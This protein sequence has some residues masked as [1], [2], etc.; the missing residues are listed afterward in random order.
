MK[1]QKQVKAA[2]PEFVT[3]KNLEDP[4]EGKGF[5]IWQPEDTPEN[6]YEHLEVVD[7]HF[8]LHFESLKKTLKLCKLAFNVNTHFQI[9]HIVCVVIL[10]Q[11][12]D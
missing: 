1:V 5:N 9:K 2:Y 6:R 10:F 3:L 8:C 4:I 12:F 11:Y 7:I